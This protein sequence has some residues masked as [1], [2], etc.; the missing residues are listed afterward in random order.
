MVLQTVIVGVA[1]IGMTLVI[2]SAGID[3]SVGSI[4]A[5]TS[6]VTALLL[7]VCWKER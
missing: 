1:A 7:K 2:I 6:V 5:L 4:I 3:L